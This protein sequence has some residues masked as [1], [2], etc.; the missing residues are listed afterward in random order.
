MLAALRR[1]IWSG[2]NAIPRTHEYLW[3]SRSLLPSLARLF[4]CAVAATGVLVG[5]GGAA[6]CA[7]ACQPSS[8]LPSIELASGETLAVL[9]RYRS[10]SG[11]VVV[12]EYISNRGDLDLYLMC[13]EAKEAWDSVREDVATPEVKE[14][15][16][17]ATD[18][19][20]KLVGMRWFVVPVIAC[21]DSM[22]LTVELTDEH[23]WR[24]RN[25]P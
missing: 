22:H 21:C 4:Y 16:F 5:C 2:G 19:R 7:A 18:P 15:V 10:D 14:V 8:K 13:A 11:R 3:P 23:E 17:G 24:F 12:I 1:A 6:D 9:D 20:K 25:C